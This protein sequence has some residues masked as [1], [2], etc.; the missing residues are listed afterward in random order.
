ML[1]AIFIRAKGHVSWS[2]TVAANCKDF[3]DSSVSIRGSRL[4]P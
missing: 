4:P 2:I 3:A 1:D